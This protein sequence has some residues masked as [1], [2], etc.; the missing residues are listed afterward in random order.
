MLP[1][2]ARVIS[3]ERTPDR[4]DAFR[5]RLQNLACHVSWQPG[6]DGLALD[7]EALL[8]EGVLSE[9]SARWP[10][11]QIGCA[12]SHLEAWSA[13][14][15][16]GKPL[17]VFEDDVI[18]RKTWLVELNELFDHLPESW[19]FLLLGWNQDSCLQWEWSKGCSATALFR[20][21]YL[22][23][24]QLQAALDISNVPQIFKLLSGFGLAGYLLNPSGA[25]RLLD[26]ALPLR[27]LPIT[28]PELPARDCFSLDGQINACYQDLQAYVCIPPLA[29]GANQHNQSLTQA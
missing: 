2:P 6:V 28:T 1:C 10:R 20:P 18:L 24:Q 23:P 3:L 27:T 8:F 25:V 5:R 26:W 17:I 9:S 21:R 13:C 29:V 7:V 12:L 14:K 4:L 11:G 19:D 22:E 15:T 16:S